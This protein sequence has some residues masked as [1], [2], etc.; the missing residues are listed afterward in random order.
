[1]TSTPRD[2]VTPAPRRSPHEGKPRL[3]V[4][5]VA[6][7]FAPD[8]NGAVTFTVNLVKGLLERGHDVQV[9]APSTSNKFTG[10]QIE[11]HDGATFPVWRIYSWRWYPQ[12]WL[13]FAIPW[14]IKQNAAKILDQSSHVTR[15]YK[16]GTSL[17]RVLNQ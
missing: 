3:R 7:T 15:E 9:A 4:L 11:T 14:R 13:R 8:V 12:P 16:A 2:T 17:G 1:M 5:V 10:K 6:D